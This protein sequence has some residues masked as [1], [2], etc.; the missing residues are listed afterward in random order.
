MYGALLYY[1]TETG[2]I[3]P[4]MAESFT[5][6]DGKVW[7]LKLR[8]GLTFTD[9]TPVRRRRRRVQ[10]GSNSGSRPPVSQ[11]VGCRQ[12]RLGGRR[13]GNTP[14]HL[15]RGQ[16]PVGL[17]PDGSPRLHCLPPTA[18]REKGADFGNNP[19]GA[20]PFTLTSWARGTEMTLDRNPTYWDQPPRPYVDRLVIRTIPADDQRFNALQAGEVDVMAVTVHKYADRAESAGMN[21]TRAALLG[22]TGVRLSHR[23]ALADPG[24]RTAIAKLTDNQQIMNAVYPGESAASGFTPEDSPLYDPGSAWPEPDVEGAQR[25]IDE[26]RARTGSGDIEL[27]YVL[28]A[29]SLY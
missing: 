24:V 10:L 7:T 8:P 28:T 16:L 14:H 23:G 6:E 25:L 26:Y 9:G 12:Y 29:G 17:R 4:G 21:V 19:V 18:I 5:T 11:R 1:D 2:E 15:R 27:T 3:Q 22:G 20:G 13:S